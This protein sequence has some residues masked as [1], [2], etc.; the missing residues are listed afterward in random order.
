MYANGLELIAPARRNFTT[1][2]EVE[3][4]SRPRGQRLGLD[5]RKSGGWTSGPI[6]FAQFK[7]SGCSGTYDRNGRAA[8]PSYHVL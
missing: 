8:D 6:S 7:T 2:S 1:A 4:S 3:T 5:V